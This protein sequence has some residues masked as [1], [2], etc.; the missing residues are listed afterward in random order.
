MENVAA[1]PEVEYD[2]LLQERA[3]MSER[4]AT[5]VRTRRARRLTG[6][7]VPATELPSGA[8]TRHTPTGRPI[9]SRQNAIPAIKPMLTFPLEAAQAPKDFECAICLDEDRADCGIH[10]R[11][12]HIF[13]RACL[14]RSMNDK[15]DCPICRRTYNFYFV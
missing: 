11:N 5:I 2:F 1:I 8:F 3:E 9:L 12:C 10:P 4:I 13:H 7:L 14:N 15:T 6:T